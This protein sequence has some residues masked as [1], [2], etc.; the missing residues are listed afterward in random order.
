MSLVTARA[1]LPGGDGGVRRAGPGCQA[2]WGE[3]LPRAPRL[4]PSHPSP[5][6]CAVESG[7]TSKPGLLRP[8]R[9]GFLLSSEAQ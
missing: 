1:G 3:A 2:W 7:S 6:F 5:E 4:P 9:G 8:G